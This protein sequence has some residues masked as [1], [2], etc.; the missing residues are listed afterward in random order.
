MARFLISLVAVGTLAACGSSAAQTPAASADATCGPSGGHTL[1]AGPRARA[2]SWHGAVYGCAGARQYRL[3]TTDRC[4][5]TTKAGP[6]VVAARLVA[7]AAT[8]CGIDI[9]TTQV[10]VRRLSDGTRVSGYPVSVLKPG[11]ES[12]S[13]V[14]SIVLERSGEVAWIVSENS[15]ATHHQSVEVVSGQHGRLR[16][17]DSGSSIVPG[18]LRLTRAGLTWKHGRSTRSAPL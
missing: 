13:S 5:G 9:G 18:S 16:G 8:S 7:Y 1:A 2:Y 12:F 17:L 14:A 15:I 10:I 4:I 3:G 11:A 6:V